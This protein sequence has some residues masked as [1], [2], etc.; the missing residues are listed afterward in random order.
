MKIVIPPLIS[1]SFQ[2]KQ[3]ENI[4]QQRNNHNQVQTKQRKQ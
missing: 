2:A 1:L 3:L 4:K